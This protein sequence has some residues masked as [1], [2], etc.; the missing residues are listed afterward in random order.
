MRKK[1]IVFILV[2][3]LA[4]MAFA[5]AVMAED[6]S[7]SRLIIDGRV[8]GEVLGDS[9]QV[10]LQSQ[11]ESIVPLLNGN[12]QYVRDNILDDY[13]NYWKAIMGTDEG[14]IPL[15]KLVDLC[16]ARLVETQIP[17]TV[18]VITTPNPHLNVIVDGNQVR[19]VTSSY[20]NVNKCSLR[21]Q[22]LTCKISDGTYAIA[23][24]PSQSLV[25]GK[26][27]APGEYTITTTDGA[28]RSTSKDIKIK[29]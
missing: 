28:E 15:F 16:G 24:G 17:N 11:L 8:A 13:W 18:T 1:G 4:V 9:T 27:L 19:V 6:V 23:L 14:C 5:P 10:I 26:A 25:L 2:L 12:I 3:A 20:I 29:Y 22:F 21:Q 7:K